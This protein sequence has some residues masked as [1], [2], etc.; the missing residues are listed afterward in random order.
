[1]KRIG[2]A[3]ALLLSAAPAEAQSTALDRLTPPLP[4]PTERSIADLA[5]WGTVAAA[6]A[7]DTKASW[8]QADR[9]RAF[10]REG[11]RLGLTYTVAEIVKLAVHRDRPCAPSCGIDSPTSSFYSLHTAFGFSTLGG[12][13]LAVSLPLAISTGG[14]RI[15]AGKHYLTDVLVGAAAGALASRLH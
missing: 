5:S 10:E 6:L 14:L 7:L 8:D 2:L 4:T 11:L 1:M 15:A 13:R 9:R 12:P 3:L